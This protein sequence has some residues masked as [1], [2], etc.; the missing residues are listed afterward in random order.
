MVDLATGDNHTG[1][2]EG[3]H[4]VTHAGMLVAINELC[5]RQGTIQ[6][7]HRRPI[8]VVQVEDRVN[9][10]E[11][12]IGLVVGIQGTN[13]APIIAVTI[14]RSGDVIIL[15]VV[16]AAH[17]ALDEP[18]DDI[19]TH[20]VLG[21]RIFC[22]FTKRG[23]EFCRCEDVVTHGGKDLIGVIGKALRVLRLLNKLIDVPV[24]TFDDTQRRR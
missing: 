20:V 16:V 15:E 3:I 9:T 11:V 22:V 23:N 13:I 24:L 19:A 18:R 8:P 21:E 6:E 14:G 4:S 1:G 7:R 2:D 12:H 5:R 10:N 17:T